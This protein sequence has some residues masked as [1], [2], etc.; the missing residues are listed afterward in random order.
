MN[1]GAAFRAVLLALA[2]Q[3]ILASASPLNGAPAP[4]PVGDP[5]A[6]TS[7]DP[8]V[9]LPVP[10]ILFRPR[11]TGRVPA[12]VLLHG[13]AG[14]GRSTYGWALWLRERG[15]AALVVDSMAPRHVRSVCVVGGHPTTGD[16]ALDAFGA[17]ALLRARFD[18][19]AG[20][21]A[22]MGWSHGGGAVLYAASARRSG[23]TRGAG[24]SF[25]AAVAFYPGCGAFPP[26][27]ATPLLL[28]LGSADDWTPPAKCEL[29]AAELQAAG[30]PVEWH[31]Y[32]DA[33]H[34]FDTPARD[35]VVRI[36]GRQFTLRFDPAAAEDAHARVEAFLAERLR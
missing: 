35:R 8:R 15:Y 5:V 13:C 21:I 36:A 34:A 26:G 17:L 2:A 25:R 10:G 22:V 18:I 29:A 24:G 7:Q 33:T 20:R 3:C 31:L 4:P 32:P 12:V 23:E 9:T 28:L 1:R 27:V 11:G 30:A 16:Q 19:D 6:I 14:I